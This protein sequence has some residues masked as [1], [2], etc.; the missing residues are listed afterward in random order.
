MKPSSIAI[1]SALLLLIPLANSEPSKDAFIQCLK[2]QANKSPKPI[3]EAIFTTESPLFVPTLFAYFRNSRFNTTTNRN[4]I[5]IITATHETHVQATVICAKNH[6][7]LLRI[8]S[9]GH[10]YEGLSYVSNE[11]FVIL[12]M[13]SLRSI[14]INI[15]AETAWVQ[16]GTTLG[17]LYYSISQKSKVHAFPG[18][19]CSSVATGGHFIGAGYGNLLRKYGLT[20]DNI[21]DA[22]IVDVN[23][24]ILDRKSMGEDV[25]WAIRGGGAS[26]GVIL[27]WNLKLVLIPEVVTFFKVDRALEEGAVDLV[28]KWQEVAG[29]LPEDIFIRLKLQ[30]WEEHGNKFMGRFVAL[31]L[32]KI[33]TLLPMMNQRFPELGLKQK[34]CIETSWVETTLLWQDMDPK[35]TNL[36][37]DRKTTSTFGASPFKVK[38]D[39]VKTSISKLALEE[40]WKKADTTTGLAM[41]WNPYGGKMSHIPESETP[42]PHRAGYKFKIQYWY[43]YSSN[44]LEP[45]QK[46]YDFMTPYASQSPREAFLNY[47]DL[48]VGKN[49]NG[50]DPNV[51][52][53][54]YFKGN[55]ERLRKVKTECDPGNFFRNEQSIPPLSV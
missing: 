51:F 19:V 24:K 55:F 31:Y 13:F 32:G 42:F 21:I 35:Q 29:K 25:F 1:L 17:E 53:A 7:L 44:T 8:R 26:F 54:K 30:H 28:Y 9:G 50:E 16:A 47:R 27:S 22:K 5:A 20:V 37:L 14:D 34:D 4:P 40:L 38:S 52:G 2:N 33:D 18:G 11:P 10:D 43:Y 39:Y 46:L 48:D 12:D 15:Q 41:E 36:L 6:S 49:G 3:S 45:L 23:G